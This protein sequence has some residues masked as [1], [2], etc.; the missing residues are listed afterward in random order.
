MACAILLK[1]V[2]IS[3]QGNFIGPRDMFVARTHKLALLQANMVIV[4]SNHD[5]GSPSFERGPF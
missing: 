5:E 1:L 4:A 2:R 3:W